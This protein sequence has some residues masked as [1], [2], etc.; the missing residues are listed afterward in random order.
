MIRGIIFPRNAANPFAADARAVLRAYAAP[1]GPRSLGLRSCRAI[2]RLPE[3]G[4][5]MNCAQVSVISA[6]FS[7][8]SLLAG[9]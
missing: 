4:V 6:R 9:P 5:S 2:W 7:G 8:L 1:L 3:S